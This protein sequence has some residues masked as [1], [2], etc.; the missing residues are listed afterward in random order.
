MP[1]FLRRIPPI[2]VAAIG[3]FHRRL[4][5]VCW[6]QVVKACEAY[7]IIGPA[8]LLDVAIAKRTHPACLAEAVMSAHCA[9]LVISEVVRA[10]NEPEIFRFDLRGPASTFR[11]YGTIALACTRTQI[12]VGLE[13]NC[14]A[15]AA[16]LVRSLHP[17]KPP[18]MFADALST[19]AHV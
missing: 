16:A 14:A 9:E 19:S 2:V 13:T 18:A 4:C 8:N 12:Q 6:I 11:A 10:G 1:R 3:I 17:D 15:M 5:Q 7:R